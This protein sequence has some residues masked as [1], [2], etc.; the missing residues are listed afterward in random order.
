MLR[1]RLQTRRS[2]HTPQPL[3]SEER[4]FARGTRTL[5]DLLAPAS[6]EVAR[7]H[8]RLE[9]QYAR[10]L[11]VIGYPRTVAAGWLTP[12]LEFEHPIEISVHVHPLETASIVK[13]LGHKLVQL[14][15]SR[16]VEVRGGR[17]AD[18]EREVAFEDAER[19]RDALQR[20]EQRVFSVS[21]YV[22]LRA[23]SP[24]AL[25]DLT[26]RVETTLDGMLAHSR[27]AILEQER[28]FRAC[29]P[30][31]RDELLAYRNLDTTSLATT[32]PFRSGSL[33]MERG[34]LYGVATRSQTPVIID[35]FDA[36]LENANLM[37]YPQ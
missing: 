30:T 4:R 24:P 31:A 1:L 7:N 37:A 35:P 28:A 12:L 16:L 11:V 33:T 18:P 8:V 23:G 15:S 10:V 6:V 9:Y 34:V 19:L 29:L 17:L 5:A 22:L 14:Q 20:G 2:A 26:R 27:V 32:F 36:S 3:S 21:L 13:L 25:D